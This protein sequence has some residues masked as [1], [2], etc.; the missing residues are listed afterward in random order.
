MGL[1]SYPVIILRPNF[2]LNSHNVAGSRAAIKLIKRTVCVETTT[3]ESDKS[4]DRLK[5]LSMLN[6]ITP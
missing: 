3:H 2:V 1:A 4:I 5:P 6:Q